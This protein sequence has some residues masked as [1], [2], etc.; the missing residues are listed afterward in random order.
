MKNQSQNS[1]IKKKEL[2]VTIVPILT[3]V[4][5]AIG[6]LIEA[7]LGG[8]TV[9]TNKSGNNSSGDKKCGGGAREWVK[10]N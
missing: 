6:V 1:W 8:S 9:S 2:A 7:L 4:G 5:V 3:A 10:N